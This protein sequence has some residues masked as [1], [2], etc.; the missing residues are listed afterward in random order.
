LGRCSAGAEALVQ[1]NSALRI[2]GACVLRDSARSGVGLAGDHTAGVDGPG[3]RVRN[4]HDVHPLRSER[5][6]SKATPL[7][8]RVKRAF[9]FVAASALLLLLSPLLLLVAVA[10]RLESPGPSLFKQRRG[11]FRGQ[12]FV[13]YKFRT[14]TAMDDGRHIVQATRDDD[15]ITVLGKFLRKTSIDE[16][17]QLFNVLKGDMSLVGPRPHALAHDRQFA[18][19]EPGY[20]GRFR[21]R[22][23]ITGLAQICGSR[24]AT[25]TTDAVRERVRHDLDYIGGWSVLRDLTILVRTCLLIFRDRNAF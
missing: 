3:L 6:S 12:P 7:G 20:R 13:I 11:G 2:E 24:G 8:G 17:P 10:V 23:G 16:L 4:L 5:V 14:M 25:E 9:D 21:A 22:P 19:V 15:R 18:S 1:N